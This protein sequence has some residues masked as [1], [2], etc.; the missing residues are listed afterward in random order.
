MVVLGLFKPVSI[1]LGEGSPRAI[2]TRYYSPRT[3]VTSGSP[4]VISSSVYSPRTTVT[5][6][7]SPRTTGNW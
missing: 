3:T 5:S 1:V 2:L 4:R 7:S 6:D